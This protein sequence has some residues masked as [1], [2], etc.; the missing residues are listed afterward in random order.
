M[1]LPKNFIPVKPF[2]DFKWKWASL[3]C[4]EG[5]NDPVVL[6]GVLF[7]MRKLENTGAKYS[8]PEFAHELSELSSDIADSITGVN[9]NT[10]TGERNLIRNS[11]QYWRAVGLI[12]KGDHSGLIKLTD[13]GRKV[14]DREI[15]QSEFAA[16]TI[17]TFK[18]P[19]P[20]IQNLEEC[21]LWV[22]NNLELYPLHLL[23]SIF[24]ELYRLGEDGV[25][26]EELIRIIIPL[27]GCKA[28]LADYVNFIIWHR[29]GEISIHNWPD[30][31]TRDNDLRIAREFLIFLNNY[32]YIQKID[33]RNR[34]DEKYLYNFNLND[35]I[36]EILSVKS[37]KSLIAT[38]NEIRKTD[39]ISEVERKRVQSNISRPYQARFRKA[40][41]QNFERC[42]ITNVS[43]A[44]VLE[45]AHIKPFKYKGEDTIANGFCMRMDI[46]QLFDAGHL[47]IDITGKVELSGRARLEYGATIPPRITIPDFVNTEYVRWRWDNYNGL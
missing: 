1:A 12:E 38:L 22:K 37:H 28:L 6:L 32:G 20:Q 4:T 31:C 8:S 17:Q 9:L 30:C 15:S 3:Q 33:G 36:E 24:K 34:L 13:Y 26:T 5:L 14:A 2:P 27:S 39:V 18:L 25:T 7:R 40:I 46:H 47:R 43:M 45:A 19:N 41:L 29:R 11:G 21:N 42:I 23:L 35:E 16:I 44:E 10:R